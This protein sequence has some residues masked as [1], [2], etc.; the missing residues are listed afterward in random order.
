MKSLIAALPKA[1]LHLHLEGSLEPELLFKIAQRNQIEIPFSSVDEL[2]RAYKFSNLQEFLDIYYQG[3]GVLQTEEDYFDL[4]MAYFDRC[5]ADNVKHVEVFF[6]P[7]G[8]T[9]RGVEF[10]TVVKGI[11]AGLDAGKAK[12]GISSFLIMSF[13]RHL[14]EA[15]GF[16][17]LKQAE[18]WL[19]HFIGIGLDSS[20]IGHPPNKFAK[21]FSE[22]RNLGLKLCMHSGEEGPIEYVQESIFDIGIDRMDHGNKSL[23]SQD[24]I[25]EIKRRNLCLTVC[26]LSNLALKVITRMEDSPVKR[27]LDAGMMVTVNSDDPAYFGGYINDNFEAV[28]NSLS[29]TPNDIRQLAINSFS[30][31]FLDDKTKGSFI[32]AIHNISV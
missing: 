27:M 6:D 1:E 28:S 16:D 19:D 21:L 10:G 13:L 2:R 26:P 32:K 9:A 15:D 17:T 4:T 7:Q 11:I 14:S 30:G 3:M 20:E 29:L 5:A 31:S 12:H 25:A 22:C 18:P 24:M 8:H 23:D